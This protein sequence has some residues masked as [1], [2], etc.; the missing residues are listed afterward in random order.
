MEQ[1]I[2]DLV[3]KYPLIAGVVM[4]IGVFR[5]I[6]KP[7]MT[8][9]EA[10]VQSTPSTKDDEAVASFK[11]GKIYAA[12]VWLVDYTTSIKLPVLQTDKSG[13]SKPQ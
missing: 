6:F 11:T 13:E 9:V 10:Y 8:L 3:A 5:A 12:L 2:L 7:L 1:F 4:V